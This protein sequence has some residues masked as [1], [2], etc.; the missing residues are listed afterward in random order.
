MFDFTAT[1]NAAINQAITTAIEPLHRRISELDET[2]LQ[3]QADLEVAKLQAE[4]KTYE[5]E[6]FGV[7]VRNAVQDY[8]SEREEFDR[9]DI[10][11]I[12]EQQ[13]EHYMETRFDINEYESQLEDMVRDV[14]NNL[15]FTISV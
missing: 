10:E 2:I 8:L 9:D 15:S 1:F 14:I 7:A 11:T 6:N 4:P 5:A 13:V 3:L 12:A